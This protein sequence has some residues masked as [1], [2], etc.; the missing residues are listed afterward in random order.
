MPIRPR[1]LALTGI[2]LALAATFAAPAPATAQGQAATPAQVIALAT[3]SEGKVTF[4]ANRTQQL[5]RA[6]M[7]LKAGAA[8]N[9]RDRNNY[10]FQIKSADVPSG[11][12]ASLSG[13]NMV[14]DGGKMTVLFPGEK[15]LFT[16]DSAAG[17]EEAKDLAFGNLTDDATS[18]MRNYKVTVAPELDIIALYPCYKV[19]LMPTKGLG[20]NSP[21]G[22]RYWIS[23]ENG[24]VMR[25]ERF[26][27]ED[28]AAYF[29]SQYD[30]FSTSQP[31]AL[32]LKVPAEVSKLKLAQ[33]TPTAMLRFA[34][35]AAAAAAGKKVYEPST[36]PEGFKLQAVDIMSL[37]GTD[38]V[39]LRYHD[40]ANNMV[41]TYRTKPTAFV[42]LMAG[43]FALQLVDKVSQ[44]AYHAPNNYAVIEKGDYLMYAYGDLYQGLL[45]QVANSVPVPV[46]AKK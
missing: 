39:L 32:S 23:K 18:L 1:R 21:P 10:Q 19:T 44:L 30:S 46:A 26:W 24:V 42:A 22:R 38:I 36:L 7:V 12:G 14:L 17:S 6:D 29:I 41:V 28:A 16:S 4:K 33:G 35:A 25:E 8:V 13:L 40:G 11:M 5:T 27:A 37:Y 45:G 31:P 9:F 20:P 2:A 15:L 43:A 34:N 3:R